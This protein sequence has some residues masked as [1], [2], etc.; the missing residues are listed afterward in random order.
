MNVKLHHQHSFL[1]EEL[2]GSGAP[3]NASQAER[4][5]LAHEGWDGARMMGKAPPFSGEDADPLWL[6]ALAW[7]FGCV[8]WLGGLPVV[9]VPWEIAAT[10]VFL[11][12]RLPFYVQSLLAQR[13]A[14]V[15]RG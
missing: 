13:G 9:K 10:S 8:L 7:I 14:R 15:A 1:S 4:D 5:A 12:R 3:S 11:A 2:P 6:R